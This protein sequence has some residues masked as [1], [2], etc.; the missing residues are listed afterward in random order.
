MET[1][2]D[3]ANAPNRFEPVTKS[4]PEAASKVDATT[5]SD[6]AKDT[7]T[8]L[9]QETEA[10]KNWKQ[11]DLSLTRWLMASMTTSY[12]NKIVHCARF[13]DAWTRIITY[14]SSTS[15]TGIQSL[16]SQ[17]KC[18]KKT[19]LIFADIKEESTMEK[20]NDKSKSIQDIL[21]LELIL[22]ILLRVPIR[23]LARLK[24]VSKLWYSVISD[25]DFAE[26]HFHHSPAATNA[27]FFIENNLAY[28]IYLDDNEASQKVV[29]PFKKKP[30]HFADLGS[31]RGFIILYEDPHFLV[32]WNPLTGFSKRISYRHKYREFH[33]YGFGY[34][35][36]QDDYLVFIAW[37][38][39]DDHYQLDYFS[40]R[41]NSWVNLDA[42]LPNPLGSYNWHSRGFF[43]NGAIHWVPTVLD[44]YKDVILS[45]DLKER[46]FSMISA[47][48]QV[49]SSCS[50]PG[51]AL[52][53]GCLALYYRNYDSLQTEIWVM[54][55]YKVHS[56]WT[57]YQIPCDIFQPLCFSSNGDIIGRGCNFSDKI[58][59]FIYNIRGDQ[60]KHF[61]DL[62]CPYHGAYALYTESLLPLP[63]DIM[64]K[65]KKN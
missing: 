41:T 52:L 48:E 64:D 61:K 6:S 38:D 29:S 27:C 58:G 7:P 31:C 47:P 35:A 1:H 16:K 54:Q 25:P 21:P 9:L 57:L 18:V 15:K 46:T 12:K 36:S 37:Q 30:P 56:S 19:E 13:C 51:L 45:F 53:G 23:H 59:Y 62:C 5:K 20:K 65:D 4:L 22:R 39:K 11:D 63:S 8:D 28:F 32:V 50:C 24:C 33:L 60:L 42:V 55:E 44:A 49:A 34:D 2:L 26:L 17:L 10:F 43:F 40:L 3:W 14:F